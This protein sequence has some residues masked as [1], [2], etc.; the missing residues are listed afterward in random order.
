MSTTSAIPMTPTSH[1]IS[2]L[3]HEHMCGLYGYVDA[4]SFA[5]IILVPHAGHSRDGGP[6]GELVLTGHPR[7]CRPE[8]LTRM[9]DV[10]G[11][12]A[13]INLYNNKSMVAHPS[14]ARSRQTS[15]SSKSNIL[16]CWPYVNKII[17]ER[18]F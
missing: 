7:Q 5:S 8:H 10:Q 15:R 14:G 6:C 3:P 16:I 9:V 2:T 13:T 1:V 4:V 11:A 18:I 12:A 17:Y